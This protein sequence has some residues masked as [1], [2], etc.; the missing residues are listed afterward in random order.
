MEPLAPIIDQMRDLAREELPSPRTCNVR[1]WDDGTF[2]A[3]I[4]HSM[5]DGERQAIRYERST[6][7]IVWEHVRGAWWEA[8]ELTGGETI[9]ESVH[10]EQ[11]I[12]VLT[13]VEP[14]YE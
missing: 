7:E 8:E 10:D 5:A 2:D 9:Y 1:L 3:V 14:P 4:Y 13:T 12:R 6:S 11:E